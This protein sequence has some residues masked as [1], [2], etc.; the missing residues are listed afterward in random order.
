MRLIDGDELL[1]TVKSLPWD[2]RKPSA[3]I[4]RQLFIETVKE[5]PTIDPVKH[6]RWNYHDKKGSFYLNVYICSVCDNSSDEKYAYC[7]HCGAKMDANE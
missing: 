2:L 7:P 6:G 3:E 5:A 4:S 1:S